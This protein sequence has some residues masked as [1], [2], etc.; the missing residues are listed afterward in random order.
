TSDGRLLVLTDGTGT[1]PPPAVPGPPP[2]A[3]NNPKSDVPATPTESAEPTLWST[4]VPTGE[5]LITDLLDASPALTRTLLAD[6]RV[7]ALNKN[8]AD[9]MESHKIRRDLFD[10]AV[11]HPL[12]DEKDVALV[13]S[14]AD[15]AIQKEFGSC[16]TLDNLDKI[17]TPKEHTPHFTVAPGCAVRLANI[18]LAR[19]AANNPLPGAVRALIDRWIL[20]GPAGTAL[21]SGFHRGDRLLGCRE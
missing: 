9:I 5:N 6:L 14:A 21:T 2:A 8:P 3:H 17:D 10:R 18:I 20:A 19:G 16:I 15:G 7:D 12:S 11:A 4:A 13:L 1:T